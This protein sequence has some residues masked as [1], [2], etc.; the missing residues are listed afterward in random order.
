MGFRLHLVE[1]SCVAWVMLG[2]IK[3]E[4][5]GARIGFGLGLVG[6]DRAGL[7]WVGLG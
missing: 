5:V 6:L 4:L 1:L 3:L 2:R 7:G